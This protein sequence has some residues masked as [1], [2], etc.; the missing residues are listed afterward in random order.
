MSNNNNLNNNTF[1]DNRFGI[2][3]SNSESSSLRGNSMKSCG[4]EIS[5]GLSHWNS[6]NIYTSNTI[7][8]KPII[9]WKNAASGIVPGGA[10]QVI[11]VNC[12][13][14]VVENLNLSN[15][16]VGIQLAF[17]D[18]N[19]LAN[20]T[21]NNNDDYNTD[22]I[23]LY[24][25]DSNTLTNNTC[26]DNGVGILLRNSNSN[27]LNNN[28]CSNNNYGINLDDSDDN[29]FTNNT[30]NDNSKNGVDIDNSDQNVIKYNLFRNCTSYAI[31]IDGSSNDNSVHHNDL[32]NNN[33]GGIQA[34]DDGINNSWN[35]SN[36][37]GNFW[38]DYSDR[39][40]GAS[41]DGNVWNIS[42]SI[43]GNAGSAD[44]YPLVSPLRSGPYATPESEPVSGTTG[45]TVTVS[46]IVTDNIG[47]TYY[48]IN[49]SGILYDMV[50]DGTYYN[51][52]IYIPSGSIASIPYN[53]TFKG[54]N[55]S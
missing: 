25:S 32:I 28:T 42:Y 35:N 54:M 27:M 9:F 34:Y 23:Y 45:E 22:G 13:G 49:V 36:N 41:N 20:N 21:C 40:S 2:S 48:K 19:T 38:L 11:L 26:K 14:V 50:I 8:E 37:G 17:S 33:A 39:Y 52:T 3:L 16:S 44:N 51:Y 29:T 18:S 10:G 7:N 53:C 30:C 46:Y 55:R 1:I 31:F 24:N 6:H 4:I 43:D 15:A 12:T 47:V 5:G